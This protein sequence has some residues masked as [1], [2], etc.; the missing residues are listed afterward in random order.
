MAEIP[1]LKNWANQ[2]KAA[3]IPEKSKM[4]EPAAGLG[5]ATQEER[6]GG[7][8]EWQFAKRQRPAIGAN[9]SLVEHIP[10]FF[11]RVR[12]RP[13]GANA[14]APPV[15]V[16]NQ[17]LDPDVGM[18][19]KRVRQ[20]H[21]PPVPGPLEFLGLAPG[22]IGANNVGEAARRL[23]QRQEAGKGG[24]VITPAAVAAVPFLDFPARNRIATRYAAIAVPKPNLA[25]IQN[26]ARPRTRHIIAQQENQPRLRGLGPLARN[27]YPDR[28]NLHEPDGNL[29]A[30]AAG[31]FGDA[32]KDPISRGE[33][34]VERV[35]IFRH[36]MRGLQPEVRLDPDLELGTLG[37][38]MRDKIDGMEMAEVEEEEYESQS[39]EVESETDIEA[40]TESEIRE[41]MDIVERGGKEKA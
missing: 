22:I 19:L 6:L 21:V 3:Y 40:E 36:R 12:A 32:A 18:F 1:F 33:R 38:G 8:R 30:N 7:C 31:R 28:R 20:S 15:A 39:E 27:R 25:P 23:Q 2:V 41:G 16:E 37:R 29:N 5:P 35:R 34:P 17:N 11:P 24:G 4:A 14:P 10:R 26:E 9:A 13:D